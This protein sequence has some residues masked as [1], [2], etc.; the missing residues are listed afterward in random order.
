MWILVLIF[1]Y[2]FETLEGVAAAGNAVEPHGP[3]RH[4]LSVLNSQGCF[5]ISCLGNF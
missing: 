2:S 4:S 3:G 1:S 5:W